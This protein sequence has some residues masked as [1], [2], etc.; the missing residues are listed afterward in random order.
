MVLYEAVGCAATGN[1]TSVTSLLSSCTSTGSLT[2]VANQLVA[3]SVIHVKAM[4]TITVGSAMNVT[5][6]VALAGNGCS[7]G[8]ISGA[9]VL[10]TAAVW[11]GDWWCTI[12]TTGS[13]GTGTGNA[14]GFFGGTASAASIPF[15]VSGTSITPNTTQSNAIGFQGEFGSSNASNT[16]QAQQVVI[17]LE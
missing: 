4:G 17:T 10:T 6:L 11:G 3:G 15:Y 5:L 14:F 13:S 9:N 16:M 2:L 7:G 12:K 1:V 8:A